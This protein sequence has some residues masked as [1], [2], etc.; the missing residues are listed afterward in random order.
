MPATA[1]PQAQTTGGPAHGGAARS[2]AP[3]ETEA[4][5]VIPARPVQMAGSVGTVAMQA[6]LGMAA[7]ME[8]SSR[9]PP[10]SV[11]TGRPE[12][13]AIPAAAAAAAAVGEPGRVASSAPTAP[14]PA[15]V[16]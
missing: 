8:P 3:P 5:V 10:G 9:S 14:A 2:V 13:R 16:E 1:G 4:R 15:A 6:P 12:P 7:R 11:T